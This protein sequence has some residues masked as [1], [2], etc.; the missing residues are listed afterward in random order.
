VSVPCP[1][2][3]LGLG[4]DVEEV[5]TPPWRLLR[6]RIFITMDECLQK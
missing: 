2:F 5:R 1:F 4:V 6:R 3:L